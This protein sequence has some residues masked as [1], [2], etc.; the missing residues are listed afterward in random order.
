MHPKYQRKYKKS[1]GKV[2]EGELTEKD[3]KAR[4]FPGLAL[5]DQEWNPPPTDGKD[6]DAVSKEV[7]GLMSQ[8]EGFAKKTRP[9]AT[10][11][12]DEDAPVPKRRKLDTP[13]SPQT[14][15][16]SL[17]PPRMR[18]REDSDDSRGRS[19][20]RDARRP[21]LDERPILYKIYNGKVAGMRDFGAF[22]NLEG[23][24]G[25]AEGEFFTRAVIHKLS[26]RI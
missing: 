11:L 8:L 21:A 10:D 13:S 22:I 7:D 17:S 20:S 16:R 14:R 25:R 15:R 4:M 18:G 2:K 9:R 3:K 24:Q 1:S 26:K 6:K 5:P 12:M 19:Y 23:I